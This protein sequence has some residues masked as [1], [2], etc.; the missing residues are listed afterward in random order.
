[1]SDL[2][3]FQDR[4]GVRWR[5]S[6]TLVE[7]LTHSSYVN[8]HPGARSNERLEFLGDAA[9]G[10]ML[11]QRMFAD[12]PDLDEGDL[13]RRR[14][15]LVR[16]STLA[17]VARRIGLGEVLILGRG[18]VGSGGRDKSTNLAGALEALVAAVLLDRGWEEANAFALRILAVDIEKLRCDMDTDYKS[19]FQSEAQS[20]Y[21]STPSY[22]IIDEGGAS[23][24]RRFTAEVL[25]D[26]R[27]VGMGDGRSKKLAEAGAA[28]LALEALGIFTD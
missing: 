7:A 5:D 24:D 12:Y 13:T 1:M 20:R 27:V 3:H 26:G 9:L 22:R 4:I 10:L 25:V 23:H 15:L 2:D 14:S 17:G 16:G 21:H 19:R 11:A 18:E 28:R 6:S 8:E